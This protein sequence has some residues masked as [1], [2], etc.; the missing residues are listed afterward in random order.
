MGRDTYS[1]RILVLVKDRE[2]KLPSNMNQLY[3]L[4]R[5]KCE[6]AVTLLCI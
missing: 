4:H 6:V 3:T 5:G 1:S 2:R